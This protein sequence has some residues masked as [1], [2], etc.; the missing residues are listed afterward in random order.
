MVFRL[1]ASL[2]SSP[3]PFCGDVRYERYERYVSVP[4][5]NL[6]LRTRACEVKHTAHTAH[7]ALFAAA[8]LK[9]F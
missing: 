5:L 7:T 1:I 4:I 9:H 3:K 6:A 8:G 2:S